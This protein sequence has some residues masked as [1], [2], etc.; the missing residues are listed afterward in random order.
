MAFDVPQLLGVHGIELRYFDDVMGGRNEWRN[1][2]NLHLWDM[3]AVRW[4][5]APAAARG[6]DSI[7][8]FA[9]VLSNTTTSAG[10]QAQLFERRT[11]VSYAV[12]VPAAVSLDSASIVTA[13][14]DPRMAYNRI[15]LLDVRAGV[16]APITQMP[17]ASPARASVEHWEPGRMTI[18]LDPAPTAA[19][20]LVVSENWYPDWR[21]TVD[22]TPAKVLRGNWT[23]ITVPIPAGAKRIELA[24]VS[25][26][27]R[28]GKV[29]TFLSLL[30]ALAAVAGPSVS[31]RWR[32]APKPA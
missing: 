13:V 11:P 7:P 3:F 8:G 10:R 22:G 14:A 31:R 26:P 25:T 5:I 2:G 28:R 27:Y 21:A 32:S 20:Y 17:P 4:V 23:L 6:L 24:F 29:L 1:L 15:V 12:V 18:A 19:S 9:R 16:T 30:V